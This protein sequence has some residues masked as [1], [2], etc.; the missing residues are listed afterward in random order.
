MGLAVSSNESSVRSAEQRAENM[1]FW[2]L[3]APFLI[4][5]RAADRHAQDRPHI[6]PPLRQTNG[7][8][9]VPFLVQ[10]AEGGGAP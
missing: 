9:S 5:G 2:A 4:A 7:G 8:P 1:A 3:K 6:R 10:A